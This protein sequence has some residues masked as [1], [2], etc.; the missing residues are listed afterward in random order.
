[1]STFVYRNDL[2][3][4]DGEASDPDKLKENLEDAQGAANAM[5]WRGV[6][7]WSLDQFHVRKGEAY[8]QILG[9]HVIYRS[10]AGG[11]YS[12]ADFNYEARYGAG[13]YVV[14]SLSVE[15]AAATAANSSSTLTP[16]EDSV[17]GRIELSGTGGSRLFGNCTSPEVHGGS[18]CVWAYQ[19]Q[20]G[21][22]DV[23]TLRVRF[24]FPQP[25]TLHPVRA[26]IVVFVVDT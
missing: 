1:M 14:V 9:Q 17:V 26:N 13:V 20:S 5:D 11:W 21:Q 10:H 7:P 23:H 15:S 3:D 22:P 24:Y 25:A 4:Q 2:R 12:L 19:A 18:G 8:K 16:G 6:D